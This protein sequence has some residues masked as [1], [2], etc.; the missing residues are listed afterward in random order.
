VGNFEFALDELL[1]DAE[2]VE[3]R[4]LDVEKDEVGGMLFDEVHGFQAVF[5]LAEEIDFGEG[6]QE[7]GKFF[8]SGLFV[9]DDDG[10]N[11]HGQEKF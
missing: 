1:E 4:H 9:V 10:V 7:E 8:A 2:T 3:A 5:T 11:G 6:F